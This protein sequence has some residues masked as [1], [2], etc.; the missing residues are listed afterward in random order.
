MINCRVRFISYTPMVDDHIYSSY[1]IMTD[2]HVSIRFC[3]SRSASRRF[4]LVDIEYGI[5][6]QRKGWWS[7]VHIY[8]RRVKRLSSLKQR[9]VGDDPTHLPFESLIVPLNSAMRTTLG[10]RAPCR[11]RPRLDDVWEFVCL[12]AHISTL[13]ALVSRAESDDRF[14]THQYEEH[15]RCGFGEGRVPQINTRESR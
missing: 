11:C 2:L 12:P 14:V 8:A 4:G 15:Y 9:I 5:D 10:V 6:Q 1:N 13:E 3:V 7:P